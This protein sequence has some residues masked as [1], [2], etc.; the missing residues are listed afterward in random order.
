MSQSDT[1]NSGAK[2]GPEGSPPPGRKL[3]SWGEIALYLGRE[4]RTVQR[5]E[6]TEGLPVHRHE[7]KKKST[8]YAFTGELDAWIK[9]RQPVDD[10]EADAAFIPDPDPAEA[11]TVASNND[12][13]SSTPAPPAPIEPP[14]SPVGKR[15]IIAMFAL[16]MISALSLGLYRWLHIVPAGQGK[17][18][19]VVLPF[20]NLSGDSKQDYVSLGLTEVITTQLGRLDPEHLGVIAPAS[21]KVMAGKPIAEIRQKLNVQYILEGS[22]QPVGQQVHIDVRLIQTSDETQAGSDSSTRELSNFL[23]V[24][25]DVSDAVARMMLATLPAS[26]QAATTAAIPTRGP[27]TAEA[28]G[29][30]SK[31][32][33]KGEILWTNR[34][35]LKES[36]ALFEEAV[37][38]DPENALAY[39]GLANATALVGQVPNDGMLPQDAKPKARDAAQRAL[40]LDPRLVEAHAVLGNVA[41]SYDWDFSAAEKEFKIALALNPNYTFTHE[42]Y[43]HLLMVEG[44]FDEALAETTHVLDLEPATPLF[45]VVKAEILYHARRYDEAIVESL[46]VVKA[47]PEFV[48]AYYWLGSSYREKK[49]YPQAIATFESAR[50]ITGDMPFIIMAIGHA[51]AVAGNIQEANRALTLLKQIKQAMLVPDIYPAA[52]YV[53]LGDRDRAFHYLDLALQQRIDRLVYLKV[54]PMADPLRSDPRFAQLMSNIG[55]H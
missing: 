22:V 9:Q 36:I 48:L 42:W 54:E 12:P 16:A 43:A 55:L 13:V 49:M 29:K 51:Q 47:H 33:L 17:I 32:F 14:P 28:A 35:D 21:A 53:G 24:E 19:L 20:A 46:S 41:M 34:G 52:I 8:V 2:P 38:E 50:K 15:L 45:H 23:R 31:A 18:R 10:P 4:V 40:K 27:I 11:N 3:D 26:S 37:H 5:W 7:H 6:K 30:S 25:S 1:P 44:R 39:A